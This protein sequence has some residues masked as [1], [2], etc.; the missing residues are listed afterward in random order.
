MEKGLK[1]PLVVI[2]LT[3]FVD[4]LGVGILIP[5]IPLLLADPRSPYFLLPSGVSLKDGYILLGFL[6]ASYSIAQF[7]ATPI[8]GQLSDHFGRK[9]ILAISLSGTAISY[10]IFAIGILTR[11]IPL[12]F[13]ARTFDGITGGNISV[14]QAAIADV[15]APQ[16]RAKAFGI[17]GAAF[18][19]GFIMGPYIG[20][21]L[22]DHTLVPWFNATTPFWFAAILSALNMLSVLIFFPETRDRIQKTFIIRWGKSLQDIITA[23]SNK[24]LR[25]LFATTF[26]YYAGF[27]FFITFFGV[28]LISKFKFTQGN[29]GD[30]FAYIG[31]WSAFT[32]A[33]TVRFLSKRF[34][35]SS[36][37]RIT[38]F[39]SGIAAMCYF[40]PTVWWQL[41]LIVP[42]F[43][44][45]NGL[46]LTFSRSLISKSVDADLQG[47]VLGIAAS[48]QAFAMSIPPM[49]SGYIAAQITP[50][51]PIFVAS[52]TMFIAAVT[53]F[54]FHRPVRPLHIKE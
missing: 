14:A 35:E 25:P 46:M 47:E 17:I 8:L 54:F 10:V 3:I 5:V 39:G 31:L 32:Q 51:A 26:F 40:L 2:F 4:L 22:S 13:I 7:F 15:T 44:T 24:T 38:L 6:T 28:F 43:A 30:Y 23:Y 49:L 11:N 16:N 34:S 18:G 52:I 12:L 27:T 45:F 9:K 41:L 19:L 1:S 21:K 42:F 48:V 29:I 37:L 50:E 20:G 53:F 33:V 36:I